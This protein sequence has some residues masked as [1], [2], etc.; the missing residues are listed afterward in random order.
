MRWVLE[1]ALS[2][3]WESTNIEN[4]AS[5]SESIWYL[6]EAVGSFYYPQ[7]VDRNTETALYISRVRQWIGNSCIQSVGANKQTRTQPQHVF[8]VGFR[9]LSCREHTVP[10]CILFR[11]WSCLKKIIFAKGWPII[12][13]QLYARWLCTWDMNRNAVEHFAQAKGIEEKPALLQIGSSQ[14]SRVIII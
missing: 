3:K 1:L 13:E 4:V 10:Y 7:N 5:S 2:S 12:V 9:R 8:A 14:R 11:R 6:M